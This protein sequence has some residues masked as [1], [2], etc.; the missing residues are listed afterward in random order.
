MARIRSIHPGCFVYVICRHLDD[1]FSGPVKVGIAGNPEA[2]VAALQ[3]ASP[4]KIALVAYVRTPSRDIAL[5]L[6]AA[7][8]HVNAEKRLYGEWFDVDP[9]SVVAQMIENFDAMMASIGIDGTIA[10]SLFER[11]FRIHGSLPAPRSAE[12]GRA[13]A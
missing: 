5:G 3:T 12:N 6:E 11:C 8:H 2:R 4:F 1:G 7:F 9:T 13:Q 10:D